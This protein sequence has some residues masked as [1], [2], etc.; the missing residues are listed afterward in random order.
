[1]TQRVAPLCI[2]VLTLWSCAT[3]DPVLKAR[4]A[5][6]H[7]TLKPIAYLEEALSMLAQH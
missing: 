7:Q 6:A 2:L 3:G 4:S 1:M 5:A